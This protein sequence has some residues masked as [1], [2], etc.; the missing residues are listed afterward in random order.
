MTTKQGAAAYVRVSNSEYSQGMSLDGQVRQIR[1]YAR[2]NGYVVEYI[3][4]DMVAGNDERRPGLNGLL[5]AAREGRF[6]AVMLL[7]VTRLFRDPV[8]AQRYMDL[9][10]DRFGLDVIVVNAPDVAKGSV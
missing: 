5:T 6:S 3:Y 2:A 10:G 7:D 1:E 8:M 4:T 9:M